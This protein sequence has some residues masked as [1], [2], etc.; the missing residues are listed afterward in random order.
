MWLR[1]ERGWRRKPEAGAAAEEAVAVEVLGCSKAVLGRTVRGVCCAGR[2][3]VAFCGAWCQTAS[4][5]RIQKM[6]E[7]VVNTFSE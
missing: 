4:V 2:G 5:R 1:G 7:A 6:P 3:G